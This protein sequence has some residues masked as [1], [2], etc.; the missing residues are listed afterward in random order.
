[1]QQIIEIATHSQYIDLRII[2][3]NLR[4]YDSK[5]EAKNIE[6]RMIFVV[7]L[8]ILAVYPNDLRISRLD[9]WK[10]PT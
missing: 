8:F 7:I 2:K 1:M 4:K 10:M 5:D 3:L 6:I 9:C